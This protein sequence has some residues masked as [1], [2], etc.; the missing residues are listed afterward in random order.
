SAVHAA[1]V[2]HIILERPGHDALA[3]EF[4]AERQQQSVALHKNAA[5][6]FYT[7]AAKF[8]QTEFWQRRSIT[9]L[10]ADTQVAPRPSLRPSP[11]SL[12]R[13]APGVCFRTTAIV[14][15]AFIV[16]ATAVIVADIKNPIVF[17]E[18]TK[19]APLIEM[20]DVPM[21]CQEV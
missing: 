4:Y 20:I 8:H 13:V 16:P 17:L 15:N 18:G 5:A 19:A 6:E 3:R 10:P 9:S 1:A 21:T 12:V 2:L 14:E 7:E 11:G